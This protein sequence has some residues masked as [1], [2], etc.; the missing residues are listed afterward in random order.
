[1]VRWYCM[2][3]LIWIYCKIIFEVIFSL[4]IG[5]IFCNNL[6]LLSGSGIYKVNISDHFAIYCSFLPKNTEALYRW[7]LR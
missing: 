2:G 6:N 1:M 7:E 3:I 4:L 5:T